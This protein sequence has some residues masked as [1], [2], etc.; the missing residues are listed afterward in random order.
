[1]VEPSYC[2]DIDFYDLMDSTLTDSHDLYRKLDSTVKI[3]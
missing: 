1:M 2:E 3:I